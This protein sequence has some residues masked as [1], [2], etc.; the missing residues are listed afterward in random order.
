MTS[1]DA[2]FSGTDLVNV[3]DQALGAAVS[4]DPLLGSLSTNVLC[5]RALSDMKNVAPRIAIRMTAKR[6]L[7]IVI[8]LGQRFTTD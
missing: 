3:T 5:A 6:D 4:C 2:E 7:A 1:P 8:S